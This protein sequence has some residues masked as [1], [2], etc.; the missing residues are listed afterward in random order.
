MYSINI[1]Y[2]WKNKICVSI[3]YNIILHPKRFSNRVIKFYVPFVGIENDV[4]PINVYVETIG[5]NVFVEGIVVA[6]TLV[7][8]FSIP[9]QAN[10]VNLKLANIGEADVSNT[11]S[12]TLFI[13]TLDKLPLVIEILFVS[14]LIYYQ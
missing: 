1:N 7:A 3:N 10:P 9:P 12:N 14:F 8:V 4:V 2:T 13:L 11:W 5:T 6:V